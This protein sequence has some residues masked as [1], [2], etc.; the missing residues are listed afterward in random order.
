MAL[1]LGLHREVSPDIMPDAN[2]REL[3]RQL[4]WTCYLLDRFAACGSKRPSLISDQ[5]MALRLPSRA[6][7]RL[8]LPTEGEYFSPQIN[9]QYASGSQQQIPGGMALL[10]EIALILGKTNQYLAGGGVKGDSHF[11]WHALSNLSKI[12]QDIDLWA[13]GNQGIFVGDAILVS[14]PNNVVLVLSKMIYHL[15]HCLLY[16]LFLPIDL[17]ELRGTGQHNSWQIEATNFCFLHA[18][19]I[20][21]LARVGEMSPSMEWHSFSGYCLASAGTV[22]VHGAHYNG[23]AGE[24]YSQ[25]GDYLSQEMR[26]LSELRYSWAEVD[27][28][29]Q[30]L[31]DVYLCHS[32]LVQDQANNPL[33]SSPVFHLE[34]FFDR[35]PGR[36]FDSAYVSFA[37][38]S[39]DA[40]ESG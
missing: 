4:F 34:D 22:H 38:I 10:I 19:A 27:Q 33:R 23:Q 24:V 20:A 32:E 40:F 11:P 17:S 30:M 14:H 13:T 21:E 2:Q 25:S 31:Q 1:A 8:G 7:S 39:P 12:R 15:I 6:D 9:P 29:R 36:T 35:Y 26:Q 3:R 18:N 28:Q 37:D 5:A 16:R